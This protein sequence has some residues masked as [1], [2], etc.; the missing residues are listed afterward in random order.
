MSTIVV[1]YSQARGNTRRVAE[2]VQRQ[3]GADIEAIQT[4]TP[5]TGSYDQVVEQGKREVEEGFEPEIK[6][7]AHDLAAYD[8]VVI[9]SPT[10][11]YTMAPAMRTF[12]ASADLTGKRVALFQTHGGWPAHALE[13]MEAACPGADVYSTFAVQ[14]DSTGGDRL[15]TPMADVE[16]WA[17][18]L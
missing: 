9:G 3:L 18:S 6:P 13:D 7:L 14:F 8:T 2:M 17:R 4:V 11:W 5:Y 12:L 16:T 1:Y 15:V 10:W